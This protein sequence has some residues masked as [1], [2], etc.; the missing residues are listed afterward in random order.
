LTEIEVKDY[1]LKDS[2]YA[3][4]QTKG[5]KDSLERERRKA[6]RFWKQAGK[7]MGL[8]HS[9]NFTADSGKVQYGWKEGFAALKFSAVEGFAIES[10]FYISKGKGRLVLRPEFAFGPKAFYMDGGFSYNRKEKK[11]VF[12]FTG[13]NSL[14]QF[15]GAN[16]VSIM[17]N[18]AMSLSAKRNLIQVYQKAF[19]KIDFKQKLS[20]GLSI[21]GDI[22]FARRSRVYV[23]TDYNFF[24]K[25][26]Q[27]APNDPLIGNREYT[28][29]SFLP[30]NALV[31]SGSFEW[32]PSTYGF[33]IGGEEINDTGIGAPEVLIAGCGHARVK[34]GHGIVT[35]DPDTLGIDIHQGFGRERKDAGREA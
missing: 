33:M 7:T 26:R 2:L 31:I 12:N 11:Q 15:N 8:F 17:D 20:R 13:G 22:E 16:P 21:Q 1:R 35:L 30:H 29:Y 25:D 27:F 9:V 5:Y 4:T 28:D 6:N 34:V 14:S 10:P 18:M 24:I 3:I 19:G 32:Q 23:N